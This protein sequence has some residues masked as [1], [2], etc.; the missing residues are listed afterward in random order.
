M[1]WNIETE[2]GMKRVESLEKSKR[3]PDSKAVFYCAGAGERLPSM[4]GKI[5]IST[6]RFFIRPAAVVFVA[7]GLYSPYP[8]AL[9]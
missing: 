3:P 4:R 9:K 5:K 8:L 2:Q 6:R 7:I 1:N